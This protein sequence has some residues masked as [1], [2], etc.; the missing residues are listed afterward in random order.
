MVWDP[1]DIITGHTII[2]SNGFL[3]FFEALL[4]DTLGDLWGEV[5]GEEVDDG[6]VRF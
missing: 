3:P 1:M 2:D 5:G 6:D 4:G